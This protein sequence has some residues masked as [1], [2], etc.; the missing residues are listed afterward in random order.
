MEVNNWIFL[1]DMVRIFVGGYLY[2]VTF[3][4]SCSVKPHVKYNVFPTFPS[5]V[6]LLALA[7]FDEVVHCLITRSRR[8]IKRLYLASN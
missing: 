1:F 8:N 4:H 3:P 2:Y 6:L 5:S 7:T